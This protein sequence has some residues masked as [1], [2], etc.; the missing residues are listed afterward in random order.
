MSLLSFVINAHKHEK[1]QSGHYLK[2]GYG[3]H[4]QSFFFGS[5]QPYTRFLPIITVD[6]L[7]QRPI[8]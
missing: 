5:D 7:S 4:F 3:S 2:F 8:I 1:L 6:Q